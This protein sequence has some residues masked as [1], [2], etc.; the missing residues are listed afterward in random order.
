M[1]NDREFPYLPSVFAFIPADN[2]LNPPFPDT[3]VS[4]F[5]STYTLNLIS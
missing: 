1:E 3:L 5:S 2:T 4:L